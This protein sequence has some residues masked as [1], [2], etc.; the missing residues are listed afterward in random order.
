[1]ILTL[2]FLFHEYVAKS[3]I[4]YYKLK[5]ESF[6]AENRLIEC[7]EKQFAKK[8]RKLKKTQIYLQKMTKKLSDQQKKILNDY[9]FNVSNPAAYAGTEKL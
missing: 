2:L 1:M 6:E 5:S 9:Y 8:K 4:P 3:F 7:W